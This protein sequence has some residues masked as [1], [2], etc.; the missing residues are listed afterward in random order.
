MSVKVTN[1]N[2]PTATTDQLLIVEA[3]DG[4]PTP[5]GR[6]KQGVY[7]SFQNVWRNFT[8]KLGLDK[9]FVPLIRTI[10][11]NGTTKTLE[12]NIDFTVSGTSVEW[13]D[14]TGTLSN[15]T[16]LQSALD[17][18]QNA[19]GFTAENVANKQSAVSTDA[20]HYYNAPYINSLIGRSPKIVAKEVT[21]TTV[22]GT[23]DETIMISAEIDGGV[24][25]SG[26]M[27]QLFFSGNQLSTASATATVI[28][29]I[30][31]ANSLV[32][33]TKIAT[34]PPI[35]SNTRYFGLSRVN[36]M[37]F[38]GGSTLLVPPSNVALSTDSG[39]FQSNLTT[40][41]Y[42]VSVK[43]YWIVTTQ[44]GA[45]TNT[46]VPRSLLIHNNR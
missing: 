34:L 25:Q 35:V 1:Q 28:I 15:Q 8:E 27:P 38:T 13:G 43:H 30:N 31:T 29:Y 2:T 24:F 45:T 22:T 11:I 42:D 21:G 16:D 20:N 6:L 4:T 9:I 41:A 40:I 12:Q 10:T 36:G 19:L 32:G 3:F 46:I 17:A 44:N 39:I 23:T 26:D 14:I 5:N 37:I 18:K 7:Y 33:A